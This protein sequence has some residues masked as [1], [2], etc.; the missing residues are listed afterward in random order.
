MSQPGQQSR[1][2]TWTL[3]SNHGHVLVAVAGSADAKVSE[4][5]AEVGISVRATLAI[6][7][8][9]EDAGYLTRERVGR[10]NHYT[11]ETHQHFRHPAEADHEIGEL[12]DALNTGAASRPSSDRDAT[13]R[14]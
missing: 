10:R 4:I 11:V 2:P 9:L 12:L 14:G 7:K 1:P 13:L 3:L 8:D 6:L 5:A